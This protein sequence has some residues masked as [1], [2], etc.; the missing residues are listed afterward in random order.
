MSEYAARV[1]EPTIRGARREAE[2]ASGR[3]MAR[4]FTRDGLATRVTAPGLLYHDD[5]VMDE[6]ARKIGYTVPWGTAPYGT[7]ASG[8]YGY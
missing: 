4:R 7:P 1:T 5:A 3:H 8:G 6:L 2:L